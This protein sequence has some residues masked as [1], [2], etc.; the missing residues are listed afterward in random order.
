MMQLIELAWYNG[1]NGIVPE[2]QT[3]NPAHLTRRQVQSNAESI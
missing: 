1:T 2:V 3:A